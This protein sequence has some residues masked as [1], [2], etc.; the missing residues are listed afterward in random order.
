MMRLTP[1]RP[2]LASERAHAFEHR[3]AFFFLHRDHAVQQLPPQELFALQFG[4][5]PG[6]LVCRARLVVRPFLHAQIQL[7]IPRVEPRPHCVERTRQ[8]ADLVARVDVDRRIQVARGDA[9]RRRRQL[10]DGLDDPAR[11]QK[12]QHDRAGDHDGHQREDACLQIVRRRE[13]LVFALTNGDA[14]L[15]A[16]ERRKGEHLAVRRRRGLRSMT[17]VTGRRGRAMVADHSREGFAVVARYS[18]PNAARAREDDAVEVNQVQ[19]AGGAQPN[20]VRECP[21]A[22]ARKIDADD[23]RARDGARGAVGRNRG[24]GRETERGKRTRVA[25]DRERLA[26]EDRSDRRKVAEGDRRGDR[27]RCRE[28]AAG[29]IEE[30]DARGVQVQPAIGGLERRRPAFRAGPVFGRGGVGQCALDAS[31]HMVA[32]AR[33]RLSQDDA[34]LKCALGALAKRGGSEV[35]D[36]ADQRDRR[37]HGERGH[38]GS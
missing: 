8:R 32:V 4:I 31:E 18:D 17:I 26:F 19:V 37:G 16:F 33:V 3:L 2:V 10:L 35:G 21:K 36:Q 11:R 29:R 6:N 22:R 7:A 9:P 5:E 15:R 13:Y 25:G 20:R 1:S 27:G 30:K 14:P 23:Q 28:G 24:D 34:V 38:L 12:D